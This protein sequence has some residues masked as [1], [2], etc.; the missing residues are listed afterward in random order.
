MRRRLSF[1][2]CDGLTGGRHALV[3]DT[4]GVVVGRE[5]LNQARHAAL[6]RLAGLDGGEKPGVVETPG[7]RGLATSPA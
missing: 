5:R 7:E 2:G 3:V 6:L 1:T 4:L